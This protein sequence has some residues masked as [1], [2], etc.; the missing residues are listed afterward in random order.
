[1]KD[2]ASKSDI[3]WLLEGSQLNHR[4][5]VQHVIAEGGM[6]LVYFGFDEVL[7]TQ[8]SIKEF[9]PRKYSMRQGGKELRPYEGEAEEF[10]KSGLEKFINEARTLARFGSYDSVVSTRDF[11]YENNTGYIVM[12]YIDGVTVRELIEKEGK[13]KPE[14][15]LAL[16]K[17]VLYAMSAIHEA[18]LLHRDIAPDNLILRSNGSLVLIDFGTAR[19]LNDDEEKT[20]TIYYKSGY[21]A[22]EQY[23][24]DM[25]KGPF[26]DLYGICATMYYMLTGIKP[27]ESIQRILKDRVV[28]LE[29]FHNISLEKEKKELIMQGMAIQS[30]ERI[31][32]V[33]A[34]YEKLYKEAEAEGKKGLKGMGYKIAL[35]I[36]IFSIM[37]VC[38]KIGAFYSK[39]EVT[40]PVA[41]PTPIVSAT[42]T[43]LSTATPKVTESVTEKPKKKKT[44]K[45][46][47]KTEKPVVTKKPKATKRPKTTVKPKTKKKNEEIAGQLPW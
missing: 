10:F 14:R 19:F 1:M 13:M 6:G 9:F 31:K 3:Y 37:F 18:G 47:K 27:Q 34:L 12:D 39:K 41:S 16:M 42:A 45:K 29:N 20:M 35:L 30:S 44:A 21:S 2:K 32:N 43:I 33:D 22:S 28:P 25:E 40:V 7:Q 38:V 23:A 8:V 5:K 36:V 11:F 4:Y 17:P 15:V 24:P 26:T 46:V